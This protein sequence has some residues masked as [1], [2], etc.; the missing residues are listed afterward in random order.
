MA[1]QLVCPYCGS[2]KIGKEQED[3]EDYCCEDCLEFFSEPKTIT[4]EKPKEKGEDEKMGNRFKQDLDHEKIKTLIAEGKSV[5]EIV[6]ETGYKLPS[7]RTVLKRLGLKSSKD[8]RGRKLGSVNKSS[9]FRA[10]NYVEKSA[11][12]K[13]EAIVADISIVDQLMAER[14]RLQDKVFKINQAIELLS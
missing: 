1:I 12:L 4:D 14:N 9:E 8:G 11:K 6:A 3:D 10:A 13:K 2:K 7:V 5:P